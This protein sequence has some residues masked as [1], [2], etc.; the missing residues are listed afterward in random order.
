MTSRRELAGIGLLGQYYDHS[1]MMGNW[2]WMWP[3]WIVGFVLFVILIFLVVASFHTGGRGAVPPPRE[4]PLDILKRRYA[5]GEITREEYEQ[6]RQDV[7][8]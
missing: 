2:W 8:R 4:T 1:G 3:L 6:M 5:A 7:E